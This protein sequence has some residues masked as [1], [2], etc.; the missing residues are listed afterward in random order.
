MVADHP[1]GVELVC[2][3]ALLEPRLELFDFPVGGPRGVVEHLPDYLSTDP[4][5]RGALHLHQHRD[6][7]AV[8][9]QVIERSVSAE[10]VFV[11]HGRFAAHQ[12]QRS[13]LTITGQ[14]LRMLCNQLLKQRLG[15]V[16]CLR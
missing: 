8:E 1:I 15:R 9:E 4:A 10:I 11:G 5:V 14:G 2:D 12:E 7:L 6:A 16:G 3:A 13:R